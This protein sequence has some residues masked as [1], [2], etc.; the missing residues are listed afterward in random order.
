MAGLFAIGLLLNAAWG[1][2][3]A[4]FF[5]AVRPDARRE[6][7]GN[8]CPARPCL[9]RRHYPDCRPSAFTSRMAESR[10]ARAGGITSDNIPLSEPIPSVIGWIRL[11]CPART[12]HLFVSSSAFAPKG[13]RFPP[14]SGHFHRGSALPRCAR[15]G[16]P[17]LGLSP[18]I[19]GPARK[20]G[21]PQSVATRHP[22]LPPLSVE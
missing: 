16:H 17:G 18:E 6:L 20:P 21:P 1:I 13:V 14:V 8:S 12:A 22:R 11:R 10:C 9:I 5:E 4:L 3:W 19:G 15:L 2:G 7:T